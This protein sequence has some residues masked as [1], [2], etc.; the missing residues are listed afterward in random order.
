VRGA[1]VTAAVC[2]I[3]KFPG[4]DAEYSIRLTDRNGSVRQ[5]TVSKGA[6][7]EMYGD[8]DIATA[9]HHAEQAPG[10][11]VGVRANRV[12]PKS[13]GIGLR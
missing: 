10:L 12:R 1:S 6:L 5:A 11:Y 2:C 13:N 4:G 8:H 9:L 7:K 3:G